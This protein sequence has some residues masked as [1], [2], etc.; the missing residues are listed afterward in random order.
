MRRLR[1]PWWRLSERGRIWP[2][3]GRLGFCFVWAEPF[4]LRRRDV[5]Q[6]DMRVHPLRSSRSGHHRFGCSAAHA[7]APRPDP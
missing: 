4:E 6:G 5:V 3:Q 7:P 2:S 1:P